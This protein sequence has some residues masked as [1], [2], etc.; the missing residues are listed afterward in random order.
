MSQNP[1]NLK[2]DERP[3]LEFICVFP[4]ALSGLTLGLF[5]AFMIWLAID[6]P[7]EL[8]G[9][10]VFFAWLIIGSILIYLNEKQ[11]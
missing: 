1:H 8:T 10:V 5:P 11:P 7:E 3:W 6:Q 9:V 4:L 2:F